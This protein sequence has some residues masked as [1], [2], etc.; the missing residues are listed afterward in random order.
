MNRLVPTKALVNVLSGRSLVVLLFVA[1]NLAYLPDIGHGFI[2][3]N[4]A[5]ILH[6]R[7]DGVQDAVALFGK[8]LG[9]Y[10]PL[11]ALSFGLNTAL[12]GFWSLGCG[13]TNLA[14]LT[15]CVLLLYV[16]AR[17]LR[18]PRGVACAAAAVWVFN[19]HG[20]N[21]AVLYISGRPS[22]LLTLFAL[23]A[24]WSVLRRRQLLAAV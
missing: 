18:I 11:V 20:I 24:G 15:G 7:L 6:G 17:E 9:F 10:R 5:W 1:L 2:K 12:F 23:A 21:M 14:L 3:D 4:L 19:F 16:L 13:L 8:S 22:L